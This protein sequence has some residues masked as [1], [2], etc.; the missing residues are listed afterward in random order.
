MQHDL[1]EQLSKDGI[2]KDKFQV[3]VD[4]IPIS[5]TDPETININ[6]D[7]V[8]TF[9]IDRENGMCVLPKV[10]VEV[11]GRS[12]ISESSFCRTEVQRAGCSS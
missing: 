10:K 2:A 9:S 8:L 5:T 11:S 7:S 3:N 6:N 1:A 4:I 12:M